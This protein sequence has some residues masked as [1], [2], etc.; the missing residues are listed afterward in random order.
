VNL[1]AVP[2]HPKNLE[3]KRLND[4]CRMYTELMNTHPVLELNENLEP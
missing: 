2:V 3:D 4:L 1:D